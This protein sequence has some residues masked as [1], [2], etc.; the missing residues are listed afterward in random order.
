M[1]DYPTSFISVQYHVSDSYEIPFS[2]TRA[3]FYNV[4]GVPTTWFDGRVERVGI[5]G[6]DAATYS[7]YL[8]VLN[9]R[10]AVPTDVTLNLAVERT[11][12]RQYRVAATI[13]IE[14]GGTSKNLTVH[15]LRVRDNFPSNNDNRYRN[16]ARAHKQLDTAVAAG[17]T[18]TVYSDS[19][20]VDNDWNYLTDV[21]FVVWVQEP[22]T[23]A[24]REVYQAAV[25]DM[26]PYVEG[27]V[28]GDGD[29]DLA[30]LAILL[31]AYNTC[32][33]DAGYDA[34]AD[35]NGDD[36]V[37]LVDLAVLLGNYGA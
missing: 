28:D 25:V 4:T 8:N 10:W 32:A 13:S 23:S 29:V 6:D 31:G 15:F 16:C 7:W 1:V 35:L 27:D 18:K 14:P 36:C 20:N 3:S 30:D 24:P 34:R 22:G 19:F 21:R 26:P 17:D 5:V 11:G 2:N 9:T 33:G 37:D 12:F